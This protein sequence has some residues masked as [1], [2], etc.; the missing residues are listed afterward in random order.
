MG[1]YLPKDTASSTMQAKKPANASIH[2]ALS[3]NYT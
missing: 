1:I 2:G 3:E